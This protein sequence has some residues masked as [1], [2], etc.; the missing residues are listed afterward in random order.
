V[1]L[2]EGCK[3][4]GCKWVFKTKRDSQGNIERYRARLVAKGFT[5]KDGIDYKET[6]SPISKKYSFRIIMALVSH[7][8]LELHQMDVKTAFVNGDLEED[9]YMD[10]PVGFAE[11]GKEHMVCKLKR[12]IYGLKQASRQWYLKFNDT[13]VSF[14][15]RKTLL[16]SVYI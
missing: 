11:E 2:L 1:E 15:L 13:I 14:G 3:R 5:H 9:V 12:S 8:D 7:Y 10:Q 16:I 6:F 4:V